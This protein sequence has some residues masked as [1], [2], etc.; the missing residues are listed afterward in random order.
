MAEQKHTPPYRAEADTVYRN[1]VETRND[2]GSRSVTMG[3]PVCTTSD[4]AAGSDDMSAAEALAAALNQAEVVP[5]LVEALREAEDK[6][7]VFGCNFP[8][9][10]EDRTAAWRARDMCIAALSLVQDTEEGK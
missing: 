1:S 4:W 7:H 8:R 5:A 3:F 9:G 2:D 10:S 6:L